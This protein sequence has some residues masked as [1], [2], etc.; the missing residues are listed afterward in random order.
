M[1]VMHHGALYN[2]AGMG[3]SSSVTVQF[4]NS[5]EFNYIITIITHDYSTNW[6]PKFMHSSGGSRDEPAR[7]RRW[8][9]TGLKG[10][11]ESQNLYKVS[12]IS[13]Q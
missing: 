7:G 12:L 5:L 6:G 8:M 4:W 3:H 11:L 1:C 2:K 10:N 13:L 9:A